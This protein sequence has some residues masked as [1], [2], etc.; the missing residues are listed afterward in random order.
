MP[1]ILI[2][3]GRIITAA[4][5][6]TADILVRGG[7][8]AMIGAGIEVGTDTE[9]H[10]AS[11]L[12]V[13]PGGIDV[14]THLET[15][16]GL[17]NT[18]DTF[19]TGT[20]AAAFGGTTTLVDYAK[21]TKGESPIAGLA[22]W[23]ARAA[24]AAIDVAAHMII[25]DFNDQTLVDMKSLLHGD[26]IT[27]FKMFMV[28]PGELLIDDGQ[29]LKILRMTGDNGALSC[30]HAE[31]GLIIE[32]LVEEAIAAGHN[33]PI[34]HARTRPS[35]TEGEATHRAIRIAELAEAPLY[36]V[37]VSASE[38]L[39]NITEARDRG[40]PIFA[41]TC[42]HYLFLSEEEYN[43]PGFEPAKYVMSPPLRAKS[44]QDALWRGLAS[45]DLQVVSTDHCPFCFTEHAHG[46]KYSKQI[47]RDSF[48]RI[49]N[50]APGVET[51]LP[52]IFSGGVVGGRISLNRFVQLTATGPA[53]LFGL[54]P[55]KGT[56]AVGS[57]AD[58]VLFDAGETWT[59]RAAEHHSRVDYSLFEGR[60]IT[61]RIKKVFLRGRMIV[62]GETWLGRKGGGEIIRRGASGA[63]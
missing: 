46:L 39:D 15:A 40:V 44:H 1:D 58:L 62:D 4:D 43:K 52:L 18:V 63:M 36:V 20:M 3:Q 14:H 35:S 48:A 29:L 51:R 7:R 9:I 31:N 23:R 5:N 19:E 47:G 55:T 32:A 12:L 10:D 33:D 38:A 28:R 42:P 25:V 34:Y 24:G 2:R 17:A 60:E 13:M 54:F 22:D 59:I 50:G 27:S 16:V 56:I 41:E 30:V 6:Y 21:Q 57:D 61:G 45:D 8:V 26:G 11:G 53:K 37:H 49:P